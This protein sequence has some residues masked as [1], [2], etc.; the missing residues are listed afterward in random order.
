MRLWRQT[1]NAQ[2]LRQ[3]RQYYRQLLRTRRDPWGRVTP[4]ET[5]EFY[6]LTTGV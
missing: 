6:A 2:A 3:R 4:D 1:W 5:D